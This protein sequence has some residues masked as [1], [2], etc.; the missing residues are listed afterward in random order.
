MGVSFTEKVFLED[1]FID[2]ENISMEFSSYL[3]ED[4][5]EKNLKISI[6]QNKLN[7][8]YFSSYQYG[9]ALWTKEKGI[10]ECNRWENDEQ[11][12][13]K[14]YLSKHFPS[15][16]ENAK[17]PAEH[18]LK[19]IVP[20]V[21][22]SLLDDNLQ[23]ILKEIISIPSEEILTDW[24]HILNSNLRLSEN[25]LKKFIPPKNVH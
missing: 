8:L 17:L 2:D 12:S 22:D 3:R 6:S 15:S 21:L 14:S 4:F 1:Y 23:S 5:V 25:F 11:L 19:Y 24:K 7:S 10:T 13:S 16:F 20:D 9:N 18:A